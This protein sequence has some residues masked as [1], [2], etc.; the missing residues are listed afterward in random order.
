MT[1]TDER[2]KFEDAPGNALHAACF[3]SEALGNGG[4]HRSTHDAPGQRVWVDAR[5][6]RRVPCLADGRRSAP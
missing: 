4:K 2:R 3:G 6:G 5:G 1:S